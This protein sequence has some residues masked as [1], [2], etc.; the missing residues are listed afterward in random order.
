MEHHKLSKLLNNST[1][2]KFVT[3]KRIETNDL[4]TGQYSANKNTGFETSMLRSDLCDYSNAYNFVKGRIT[5]EGDDDDKK[6]GKKL[7]FKNNVLFRSCISK[8]N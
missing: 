8:I 4:S 2:L 1:V 7:T 6:R 3:K 5:V